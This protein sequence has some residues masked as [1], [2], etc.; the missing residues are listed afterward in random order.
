MID[1]RT[2]SIS[3]LYD[4]NWHSSSWVLPSASSAVRPPGSGPGPDVVEHLNLIY[5][6]RVQVI[7]KARPGTGPKT[8]APIAGIARSTT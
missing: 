7:G 2:L 6:Q 8:S 5:N 1:K 3:Q 4:D